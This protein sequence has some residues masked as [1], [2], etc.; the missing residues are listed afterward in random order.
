VATF[1]NQRQE[2]QVFAFPGVTQARC[3][4]AFENFLWP[5]IQ[6]AAENK[7]INKLAG[8]VVVLDPAKPFEPKY[9]DAIADE[10][11]DDLVLWQHSFGEDG[12][13]D[14]P[15][16][17]Q[18]ARV[19]AFTSYLTG[20]PSHQAQQVLPSLYLPGMIKWGG[21][22]VAGQGPVRLIVAFSGVEWYFDQMISEMMISALTALSHD[23]MTEAMKENETEAIIPSESDD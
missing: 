9:R 12:G 10:I 18:F 15:K 11:F 16:Y 2:E 6:V 14:V 23:E 1:G 22:A 4:V 8:C 5:F 20:L 7:V 19:K 17:V 21:S 3:E 13:H